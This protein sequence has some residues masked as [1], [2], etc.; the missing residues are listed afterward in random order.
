VSQEAAEENVGWLWSSSRRLCVFD[1]VYALDGMVVGRK[2]MFLLERGEQIGGC[3]SAG[4]KYVE[5]GGLL[6][7]EEYQFQG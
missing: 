2:D 5:A 1:D 7:W 3:L 6:E 4:R